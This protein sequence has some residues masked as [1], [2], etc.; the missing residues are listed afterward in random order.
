MTIDR[1]DWKEG[2]D[3]GFGVDARSLSRKGAALTGLPTESELIKSGSNSVKFD[4]TIIEDSKHLADM[5]DI[6]A[7]AAV[8]VDGGSGEVKASYVGSNASDSSSVY[9]LIRISSV[10]R[11]RS[12]RRRCLKRL[13]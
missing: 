8:S 9:A 7:R 2:F 1:V 10:S 12:F 3:I 13:R 11:P 4:M 5:L 6:S